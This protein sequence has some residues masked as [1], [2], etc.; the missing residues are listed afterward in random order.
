MVQF[1]KS[2]FDYPK[3]VQDG[4]LYNAKCGI[5]DFFKIYHKNKGSGKTIF[6]TRES[7]YVEYVYQSV[8][9][10]LTNG[11]KRYYKISSEDEDEFDEE[12]MSFNYHKYLQEFFK[13]YES[14]LKQK[15]EE[16]IKEF[17]L[18]FAKTDAER[19]Y[20]LIVVYHDMGLSGHKTTP[21]RKPQKSFPK[22]NFRGMI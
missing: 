16:T 19:D 14:Q 8:F 1:K 2:L 5:Y 9:S 21:S 6:P 20:P 15:E 22:L 11:L 17:N 10:A 18:H 3:Y 13:K 4:M 7:M 12:L